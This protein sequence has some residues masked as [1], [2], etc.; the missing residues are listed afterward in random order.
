[1]TTRR[2]FFGLLGG[3]AAMP[4]VAC[5]GSTPVASGGAGDAWEQRAQQLED[6]NGVNSAA[7]EGIWPGKAATHVPTVVIDKASGTATVSSTHPMTEA[8]WLTTIYVRDQDGVVIHLIE[9]VARGASASIAAT[10][11]FSIPSGTTAMTAY[12]YCNLHDAW[13]TDATPV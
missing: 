6:A 5:Y 3:V 11:S 10:T 1:M 12:A 7:D 2:S 13:S 8:H 4:A 9:F